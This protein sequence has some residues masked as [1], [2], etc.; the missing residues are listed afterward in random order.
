VQTG[1][2]YFWTPVATH[3]VAT[4]AIR[5]CHF[6]SHARPINMCETYICWLIETSD[7]KCITCLGRLALVKGC[8][9]TTVQHLSGSQ[10]KN[11]EDL[12]KCCQKCTLSACTPMIY[13]TSTNT[14]TLGTYTPKKLNHPPLMGQMRVYVHT[15]MHPN[16]SACRAGGWGGTCKAGA[17]LP[18]SRASWHV[19]AR[20]RQGFRQQNA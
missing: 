10:L 11:F 16:P 20:R 4:S 1:H 12:P 5:T 3:E 2:G 15:C 6:H 9:G 8:H 19:P 13:L 17:D 14:S 18:T 7:D